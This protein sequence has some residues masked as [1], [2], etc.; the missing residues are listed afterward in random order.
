MENFE[1]F[2]ELL[3]D[4]AW[5]YIPMIFLGIIILFVGFYLIKRIVRVL[6]KFINRNPA[7]SPEIVSFIVGIIDVLLKVVLMLIVASL[8]GVNIASFI[9]VLA[10]ASFAIGMAL[11]GSLSNF[12]AGIIIIV[13][14]PYRIGDWVEIEEKFGKIID[15]QLFNTIV[16]SPGFKTLIIPNSK[17]IDGVV[18][19]FSTKGK[20]RLELEVSIPYEEDY[21]KIRNIIWDVLLEH[22]D[23]LKEPEPEFGIAKYDSHSLIVSIKPFV[24]PDDFWPVTHDLYAKIKKAFHENGVKVA[25]SEGVELGKIGG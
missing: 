16:E 23:I 14:K 13:F 5:K 3:L 18:T 7:F 17:V 24:L 2:K 19:N 22:P 9:A 21:N 8:V 6:S 25:Y 4:Y 20:I 15:I 12:A 11:Q 10:A 1:K